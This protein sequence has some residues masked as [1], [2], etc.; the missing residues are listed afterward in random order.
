MIETD[1]LIIGGGPAGAACARR[2]RQNDINCLILDKV[3]F[4]RFKP[5][6]GWI[7]PEIFEDLNLDV[8]DYPYGLTRFISFKIAIKRLKFTLPTRQYAI[9]RYE[10]DK[11]LLDIGE[12]PFKKHTVKKISCSDD[13]YIIDD[14]Y[15]CKYLVGAGG[16]N[17]P[18]RRRFFSDSDS[19]QEG[20]LI[21]AIEEEFQYDC[22]DEACH[23]WF[24]QNKLPGYA[25][26]VPKTDGYVNVGI[27]GKAEKLKANNDS[28]KH[29]W[30]RLINELDEMG[31][32]REHE[33][34]PKGH[35]Y[36]LINEKQNF[37]KENAFLIGDAAGL[38]TRDMGEGIRPAIMSGI[39]AAEAMITGQ[40]YRL[41]SIPKYSLPSI[42]GLR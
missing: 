21:I 24:M 12:A 29:H 2:L 3:E 7:T 38:A 8:T 17:C 22:V 25:W 23:L 27:G 34:K 6:A 15:S 9:R 42:I 13:Q 28:L 11:W 37:R 5:C 41:V 18:V 20:S 1:V 35:S 14:Q 30:Q 40:D 16:T 10:F 32:V 33:Y 26:Y 4:P 31:L 39:M 36:F 19:N